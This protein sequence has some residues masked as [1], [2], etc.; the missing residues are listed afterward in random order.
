MYVTSKSERL[1]NMY[2]R[3]RLILASAV[4]LLSACSSIPPSGDIAIRN[5]TVIDAVNGVMEARTVLLDGDEIVAVRGANAQV[6]A[7]DVIDGTGKF[8]IPGL[9]DF[10]VHLTYD[11]RLE[12]EMPEL[13]LSWGITSVRDTGGLMRN[14][15]PVAVRMRESDAIAP[16]VFFAGPLLDGN[17]VVYDGDG[18]PEIG[19]SVPTP[20]A[21]R[22]TV[23][24]LAEQGVSFIKVYEMTSP[25]VFATLVEAAEELGL[26]IDSHVPLSMRA[27]VAGPDVDSIEHL[28]NI[29]MDCTANAEEQMQIRRQRLTNPD[30]IPGAAL[31]A[32]LHTLQRMPSVEAY[33]Q[34]QC[35][36]TI[37]A[38]SDTVMVPT[39]RLNAFALN[40][41]Y[42]KADWND[43][44]ARLPESVRADWEQQ[45]ESRM[46]AG[47]DGVSPF[48]D[49]SLFLTGR[50][51]DA[52]VPFGAGTDTPINLSIPG[53]SLH[54]ELEMLV[55]AGLTPLEAIA[56]ATTVPAEYFSI[57]EEMGTIEVGKRADLVL[58]DADPL[59]DIRNTKAIEMVFSKGQLVFD[60]AD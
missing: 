2:K 34:A 40:P 46:G 8:L 25:E 58:L 5:V 55:R 4:L 53:Y 49:W 1:A 28:R 18:R 23:A 37:A 45:G 41:P 47:N 39:L 43:A 50:M 33:D 11:E 24:S 15:V 7:V 21:A 56:A 14:I 16:R 12:D 44:L 17:D 19:I 10:H 48:G 30:G 20:E 9:W 42:R 59:E 31:R 60:D 51:H 27:S 54:S 29:E 36:Q 6:D 22:Q 57:Q 32:S 52:G 35:D 13:F 38:L 3:S 26:P